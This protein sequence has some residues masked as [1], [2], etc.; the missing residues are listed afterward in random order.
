VA[1]IFPEKANRVPLYLLAGVV[2]GGALVTLVV[3]YY[4][5]PEYTDVG[6]RPEQP[7]FYSHA[8]HAGE[9]GLDCRYCH[10][11]VE[12]STVASV[13]P[14]SVCMN[15]HRLVGRDLPAVQ[16]L[17]E[18][19][20]EGRPLRWVRV[21]DLPDY[22]YFD[23]ALHLRAGVGCS[24]CHGDVRAMEVVTQVEPL[25]M[26]W[27]LEC[28]RDPAPHLREMDELTDTA[29]APPEDQAERA[30]AFIE[31][32]AIAPPTDCQGCHR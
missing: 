26:G 4:F 7:V 10:A 15:C 32:R 23:H 3:W 14:T 19:A 16:P 31:A 8:L 17:L 13:P 30:A 11:G 24:S 5:S 9:L 29:W 18:S 6:Y 20:A 27:C 1:Q 22:A 12:V 28:H 2:V 25:S 21:H